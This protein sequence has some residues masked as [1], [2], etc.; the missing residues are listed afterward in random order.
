MG[1]RVVVL[2]ALGILALPSLTQAQISEGFTAEFFEDTILPATVSMVLTDHEGTV[3]TPFTDLEVPGLFSYVGRPK[4]DART[5][6]A[7]A[8]QD[9]ADISFTYM[10]GGAST[11]VDYP[12]E[13]VGAA[14][15][16]QV[17]TN[18]TAPALSGDGFLRVG[19]KAH[20]STTNAAAWD[21][22]YTDAW[23][24]A[25]FNFT[26]RFSEGAAANDNADGFGFSYVDTATHGDSGAFY[27]SGEEPSAAG[28]GV[29]F[30]I[31]DNCD[32]CPVEGGNSV[33]I[34]STGALIQSVDIT[35]ASPNRE[36]F[37]E[38]GQPIDVQLAVTAGAGDHPTPVLQPTSVFAT[39][40]TGSPAGLGQIPFR[41]DYSSA[42]GVLD[43]YWR[44]ASEIN[45][46][47]NFLT[48]DA[49]AE[50]DGKRP[51]SRPGFGVRTGGANHAADLDNIAVDYEEGKVDASFDFR[52]T[53]TSGVPADGLSFVLA[54]TELFGDTGVVDN[55]TDGSGWV[56][57]EDPLLAGSLGF[58]LKT[59]QDQELRVRFDGAAVA[60]IPAADL[61]GIDFVDN[62]WHTV[63]L[64]VMD[65]GD[66]A[67]V[68][69]TMDDS[70]LY[71]GRIAG[72]A[73]LGLVPEPSS[74][75]L[76]A[77]ALLGV[78]GLARRKR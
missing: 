59:Y 66:D 18:T 39:S 37:L 68:T 27:S 41:D 21:T 1:R 26:V 65:V 28:L 10:N 13:P 69:I 77:M 38:S 15:G 24:S 52:L 35:S 5:G 50:V 58:A 64:S 56:V 29:G 31:W 76:L 4:F 63:N 20:A 67:D 60:T 43:G 78:I 19:Y 11:T 46:Q 70:V 55:A 36:A 12:I 53:N 44:L 57:A 61:G 6:G 30:D 74:F 8:D 72:A 71:S 45:S 48:F 75:S 23:D 49:V 17:F 34:H 51:G 25:E 40:V 3:V 33:S 9:V 54:S 22:V 62:A 2:V 42:V 16:P 47:S 73:G 32:P 14:P 7:T